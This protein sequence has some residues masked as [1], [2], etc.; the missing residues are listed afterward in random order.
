M[1]YF[2]PFS[3][4]DRMA[5][6]GYRP[7]TGPMYHPSIVTGDFNLT[8]HSAVYNFLESGSLTYEGLSRLLQN[9]GPGRRLSN[10][11]FPRK[12]GV[13]DGC[14]VVLVPVSCASFF[15]VFLIF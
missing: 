9:Y 6:C 15:T 11:L 14:Q 7:D 2:V 3:E 1:P 13:T 5:F 4:L 8:P 12:L 10:F